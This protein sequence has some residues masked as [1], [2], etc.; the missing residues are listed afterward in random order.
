[1]IRS[2]IARIRS[3]SNSCS[4]EFRLTRS[5]LDR[6]APRE[7]QKAASQARALLRRP[8]RSLNIAVDPE[9][10]IGQSPDHGQIADH[11]LQQ[12]V[13]VVG[14]SAGQVADRFHLLCLVQNRL[15]FLPFRH[16]R[17]QSIIRI[18][19]CA[20][21]PAK[22]ELELNVLA[23]GAMSSQARQESAHSKDDDHQ[24]RYQKGSDP[25]ATNLAANGRLAGRMKASTV[26][27]WAELT[28]MVPAHIPPMTNA[29]KS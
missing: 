23:E 16:L 25:S 15:G 10:I 12:I 14:Y 19:Q 22:R 6:L 27:I 11:D 29:Q 4:K 18:A 9:M 5:T 1:M 20:A 17:T 24:P 13:E 7:S 26:G 28:D 2:S 8:L 3:G 21:L